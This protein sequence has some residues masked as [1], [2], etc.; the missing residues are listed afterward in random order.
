MENGSRMTRGRKVGRSEWVRAEE[1]EPAI[2]AA[3]EEGAK[4]E[5]DRIYNAVGGLATETT[6]PGLTLGRIMEAIGSLAP[7]PKKRLERVSSEGEFAIDKER[8]NK[9]NAAI[10]ALNVLL[11]RES[12]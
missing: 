2:F 5:R 9:V 12:R 1:V 10:D 8:W 3:R 6:G 11:E 4:A 7:T